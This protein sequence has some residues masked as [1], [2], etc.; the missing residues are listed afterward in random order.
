M[1]LSRLLKMNL[2][3][4]MTLM[5]LAIICV[6]CLAMTWLYQKDRNSRFENRRLRVQHQTETAAGVIEHFVRAEKSGQFSRDMAQAQAMAAIKLLRYGSSGYF[7]INDTSPKMIMHPIKP[8]L[9]GKDLSASK[10]PNGKHLFVEFAKVAQKSGG[11]FVDYY[12]PKPGYEKPVSKISY[13]KLIPAW[14]WIVGSGL[15]VDDVEA[16]LSSILRTNITLVTIVLFITGLLVFFVNRSITGPLSRVR[17]ALYTLSQGNTNISV[18]CGKPVN[19]SSKK[20]AVK[21]IARV[22]ARKTRVG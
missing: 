11:G 6:F 13:V 15:Y 22:T 8:A 19:C 18:D 2:S 17:E 12:W 14:G 7:W 9:D 4:K 16:E 10:D 1:K 20:V 5:S 3:L 21:R